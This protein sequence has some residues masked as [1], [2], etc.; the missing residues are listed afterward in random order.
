MSIFT[1]AF[2]RLGGYEQLATRF[3]GAGE[4]SGT[5][6]DARCVQFGRSM[7]YDWC[8]T[9][10]AAQEGLWVQAK[11]PLQGVQA[12]ICVPWVEIRDVRPTMLYWRQAVCLT[13]GEP[14]V[15]T[16]TVWRLMWDAAGPLWEAARAAASP[17]SWPPVPPA[18]VPPASAPPAGS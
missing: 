4:P 2:N 8:V 9:I 16:I 11:P 10:I 6:W 17:G 15:G 18:S 13:C 14:E 5:R 3:P 12:A 1:K 7:R